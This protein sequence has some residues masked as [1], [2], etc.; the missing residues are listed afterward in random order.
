MTRPV[1]R[2]SASKKTNEDKKKNNH[3]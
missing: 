3:K 1:M 2:V